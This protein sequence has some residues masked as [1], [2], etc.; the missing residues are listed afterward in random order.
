MLNTWWNALPDKKA[1]RGDG[2]K[3]TTRS[4]LLDTASFFHLELQRL[5]TSYFCSP[6]ITTLCCSN[7]KCGTASFILMLIQKFQS[8]WEQ[9]LIHS[10]EHIQSFQKILPVYHAHAVLLP[11][12]IWTCS[13]SK[14]GNKR[15]SELKLKSLEALALSFILCYYIYISSYIVE[16]GYLWKPTSR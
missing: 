13:D 5:S 6:G 16:K 9:A 11:S 3:I 10:T 7:Q 8:F 2:N 12:H 14:K 15:W 1:Y 4:V